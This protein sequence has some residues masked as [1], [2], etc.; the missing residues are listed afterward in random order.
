MIQELAHDRWVV[1]TPTKTGTTS[2]TSLLT[3]RTNYG[4]KCLP[5][6]RPDAHPSI[7]DRIM[8]VRHPLERFVS[9][10]RF[11][12]RDKSRMHKFALQGIEPFCR[13][14]F[15]RYDELE[16]R[17]T[18]DEYMWFWPLTKFIDVFQPTVLVDVTVDGGAWVVDYF[19]RTYGYTLPDMGHLRNSKRSESWHDVLVRL[20]TSLLA[21]VFEWAQ[22]D[23]MIKAIN[24][25]DAYDESDELLVSTRT[26]LQLWQAAAPG[27]RPEKVTDS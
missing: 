15:R 17:D 11:L 21:R 25:P 4:V 2:L 12:Q 8:T 6:H 14:Y 10:Y 9:M 13:E 20:P 19:E 23:M 7:P 18:V 3:Q 24:L 1:C 27:D 22:V 26:Q 5:V 16:G